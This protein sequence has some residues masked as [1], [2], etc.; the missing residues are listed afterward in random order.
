M[1]LLEVVFTFFNTFF[2][3]NTQ[4]WHIWQVHDDNIYIIYN[5]RYLRN[6]D[7]KH[8]ECFTDYYWGGEGGMILVS[9]VY[10]ENKQL[11]TCVMFLI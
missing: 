8:L 2:N 10:K 9:N 6:I 3:W 4:L 5:I 1:K 11:R 7:L